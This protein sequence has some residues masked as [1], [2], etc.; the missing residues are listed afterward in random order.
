MD[1]SKKRA[2]NNLMFGMLG[3][4]ML[5][6]P[7]VCG[8]CIAL[9][10]TKDKMFPCGAEPH[11]NENA[12]F[13]FGDD[14]DITP[15]LDTT[16]GQATQAEA[17]APVEEGVISTVEDVH[18]EEPSEAMDYSSDAAESFDSSFV[19]EQSTDKVLSVEIWEN[20]IEPL[21]SYRAWPLVTVSEYNTTIAEM[22]SCI[23]SD[24]AVS[25]GSLADFKAQTATCPDGTTY[26]ACR[27]EG[28]PPNL[29]A[30]VYYMSDTEILST[31]KS[32]LDCGSADAE[33]SSRIANE[34]DAGHDVLATLTPVSLT[35]EVSPLTV[36]NR[37]DDKVSAFIPTR[38]SDWEE[39][40]KEYTSWQRSWDSVQSIGLYAK[41]GTDGSIYTAVAYDVEGNAIDS[42][43]YVASV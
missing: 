20:K 25:E 3:F 40:N 36:F 28:T 19:G 7:V 14:E 38:I 24:C 43:E 15:E 10:F 30:F 8:L 21:E 27:I 32:V 16:E 18:I 37:F 42:L 6:L 17:P 26:V 4:L 39:F 35:E 33:F 2:F 9:D 34:I 12:S 41:A 23:E 29:T 1:Y 22:Y 31:L 13:D 11:I 5:L